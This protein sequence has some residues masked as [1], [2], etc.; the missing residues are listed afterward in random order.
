[1]VNITI[2]INKFSEIS[3]KTFNGI[4][5]LYKSCLFRKP[6]NFI[7]QF[8]WNN[9]KINNRSFNIELWGKSVGT[10]QYIN[11]STEISTHVGKTFYYSI[12]FV[13]YDSE[14]NNIFDI[15]IDI[16]NNFFNNYIKTPSNNSDEIN[17]IDDVNFDLDNDS[18][19]CDNDTNIIDDAIESD[20]MI[21]N[22][23]FDEFKEL[24]YEPYYLSSDED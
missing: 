17:S 6:D 1:M 20:L 4:D 16:W 19:S 3:I 12:A 13:F 10:K 18:E 21:N 22:E 15:D 5:L 8:K 23:D 14:T 9:I 24:T 11:N 7:C 2:I